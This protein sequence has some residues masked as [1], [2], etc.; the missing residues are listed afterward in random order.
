MRF[1]LIS[2]VDISAT[3]LLMGGIHD[4]EGKGYRD[5][6]WTSLCSAKDMLLHV[7]RMIRLNFAKV[8]FIIL[9]VSFLDFISWLWYQKVERYFPVQYSTF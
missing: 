9:S 5:K 1:K 8:V 2:A 6:A 3:R 7:Q 4:S